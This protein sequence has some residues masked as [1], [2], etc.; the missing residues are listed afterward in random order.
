M[1]TWRVCVADDDVDA[2]SVLVEGLLANNYEA[3]AVYSGEA[4]LE[5]CRAGEVDLILLDVAMPDV[6]GFSVCKQLKEDPRTRDIAVVFVTVHGSEEN[7]RRGFELGAAD[8][9]TKPYNLPF[10]MLRIESVMR[11]RQVNDVLR[12]NPEPIFDPAYTD[13]LTGLRNRRYLLERLQEEVEKAQRYNHPVSCVVVEVDELHAVE[14]DQGTASIDDILAELALALRNAS[15]N[16]DVLARYDGAIF[17]AV[18]PH[19]PLSEA[20]CYARKILREIEAVT[21]NDPCFPTQAGVSIGVVT[22]RNSKAAGAEQ[23]LGE[24]MKNLLRAKSRR[25]PIVAVDLND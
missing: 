1:K 17:A 4:A 16:Y 13:Y 11:T 8:Y 3:Q 14:E 15:R 6:D 23:V 5:A 19:S 2:A 21:F 12:S 10:V 7:V 22:C 25:E 20:L 24:A 9:V 18:L